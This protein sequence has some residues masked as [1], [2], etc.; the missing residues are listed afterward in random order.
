LARPRGSIRFPS[1]LLPDPP[2]PVKLYAWSFE[3]NSVTRRNLIQYSPRCDYM[4]GDK[5]VALDGTTEE[6]VAYGETIEEAYN[7]AIE[8]G[9]DN[10]I[11]APVIPDEA[12]M[13]F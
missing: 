12:A 4:A 9:I 13:F 1:F 11:I 8:K 3:K 10:P 6:V 5:W 2:I 7:K